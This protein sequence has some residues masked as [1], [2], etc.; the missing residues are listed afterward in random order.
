MKQERRP[1][2]QQKIRIAANGL[3]V[4]NWYVERDTPREMVLIHRYTGRTRK[5]PNGA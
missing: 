4:D 1:T 3:I 5:I 2:R